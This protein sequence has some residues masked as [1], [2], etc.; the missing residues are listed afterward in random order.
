[1]F[2]DEKELMPISSSVKYKDTVYGDTTKV[3]GVL[4]E[5]IVFI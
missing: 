2:S 3:G 4:Q 5:K 1:M